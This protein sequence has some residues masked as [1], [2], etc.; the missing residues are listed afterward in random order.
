MFHM[1]SQPECRLLVAMFGNHTPSVQ[2]VADISTCLQHE[3]ASN[4]MPSPDDLGT[5]D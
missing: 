3:S 2:A 1:L 4:A 5:S